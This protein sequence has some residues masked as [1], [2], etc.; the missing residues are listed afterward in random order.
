MYKI[1]DD[2]IR[3]SLTPYDL[4]ENISDGSI[5]FIQEVGINECQSSPENQASYAVNWMIGPCT[6]HAWFTCKELKK[7]CNLFQKIAESS[8][9]S[10]GSGRRGV[11]RFFDLME[12]NNV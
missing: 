1:T 3:K 7:H 11:K 12:V 2:T 4:V 8:C 5:G 10:A 9:H 6:K